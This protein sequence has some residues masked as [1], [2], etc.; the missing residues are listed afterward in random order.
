MLFDSGLEHLEMFE[1]DNEKNRQPVSSNRY[2]NK[3]RSI[4]DRVTVV[5]SNRNRTGSHIQ[6]AEIYRVKWLGRS[7]YVHEIFG[8]KN[9]VV[10]SL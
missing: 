10:M 6:K 7:L 2:M 5:N 8:I 4:N 3:I 1:F 9:L